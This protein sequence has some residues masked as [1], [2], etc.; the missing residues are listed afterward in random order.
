LESAFTNALARYNLKYDSTQKVVLKFVRDSAK[1]ETKIIYGNRPELEVDDISFSKDL[2]DSVRIKFTSK[3]ATSYNVT[4]KIN[5][6]VQESD[7]PA[8]IIN[9]FQEAYLNDIIV[10]SDKVFQLTEQIEGLNNFNR[11]IF[12][13]IFIGSYKDIDKKTYIFKGIFN[14]NSITKSFG[15]VTEP[16]TSSL[17]KFINDRGIIY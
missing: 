5:C 3:Q 17:I 12:Y 15:P 9:R 10:P 8:Y 1:K 4:I 2:K 13:F 16:T 7:K 14:Y 6:V 11:P